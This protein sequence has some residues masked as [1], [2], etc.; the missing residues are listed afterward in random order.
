MTSRQRRFTHF[1]ISWDYFPTLELLDT[2][3]H[4]NASLLRG[5]H[6]SRSGLFPHSARRLLAGLALDTLHAWEK[7]IRVQ[8]EVRIRTFV[9]S[10]HGV[11]CTL[12]TKNC[13]QILLR[14]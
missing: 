11:I 5:I 13:S 12:E 2:I 1:P 3:T 10:S 4:K 14:R 8:I 7:T 9:N 6:F